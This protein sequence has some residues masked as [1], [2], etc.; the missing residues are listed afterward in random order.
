MKI[1]V[2]GCG[3]IGQRHVKNLSNL[4]DK[5]FNN[6]TV[7]DPD[8]NSFKNISDLANITMTQNINEIYEGASGIIIATP[9]H[10]HSK[11]VLE[12]LK[13]NSHILVEKPF[14]HSFDLIDEIT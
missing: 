14:S 1:S 2:I 6:V 11:F 5:E 12:G 8:P 13:N 10:L 9:N 3:S 4:M 7:Y